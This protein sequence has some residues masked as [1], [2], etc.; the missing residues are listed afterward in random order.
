MSVV[1]RRM[2]RSTISD[3]AFAAPAPAVPWPYCRTCG[4]PH[5]CSCSC[6]SSSV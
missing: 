1:G 6:V 4:R 2:Q 5:R 3:H